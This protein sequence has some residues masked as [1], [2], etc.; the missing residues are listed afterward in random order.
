M[1]QRGPFRGCYGNGAPGGNKE[2]GGNSLFSCRNILDHDI[3]KTKK[4]MGFP[5]FFFAQLIFF[6]LSGYGSDRSV[7][8]W[9]KGRI[10]AC[11]VLAL[12]LGAWLFD[13]AVEIL[14]IPTAAAGDSSYGDVAAFDYNN[15][16]MINRILLPFP[17][18]IV[19]LRLT[20]DIRGFLISIPHST[21]KDKPVGFANSRLHSHRRP[22]VSERRLF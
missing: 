14:V 15:R 10:E 8:N 5:F 12:S 17:D 1:S 2:T 4:F 20:G 11:F 7:E 21:G 13:F 16:W 9:G 22:G 3:K 18:S 19:Y 6:F